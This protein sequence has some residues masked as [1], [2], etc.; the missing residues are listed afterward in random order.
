MSPGRQLRIWLLVFLAF[1][2]FIWL[3]SEMLLPFVAGMAIAYFL[4]P[5]ADRLERLGAPRWMAATIVL[6]SFALVAILAFIL[7]LPLVRSQIVQFAHAVPGWVAWIRE[8]GIPRAVALAE[9]LSPEEV[10]RLKAA[11]SD[12]AGTAVGWVAGMLRGL[13]SGGVAL[14]DVIS[15]LLITPIVAFYLL[16]D[17][18]RLVGAVDGWLPR[19]HVE[20]VREQAREVDD[21]L[22][23][24][25]RGQ[26]TVCLV[27][28]TFYAVALSLAGL[29]FGLVIGMTAGLL[30][31]IPYVGSL[32]GF[33]ASVGIAFF[34]Y[35]ELWRVGLVVGIFIFGQAVEGNFLTPK[36]VG[37]RVG[38]HPVWVMFALLAGGSLYG[39]TGVLLAVPVAAVIGVL[40]RFLLTQYLSSSL[41]TGGTGNGT[42]A[43]PDGTAGAPA[44]LPPAPPAT[45]VRAPVDATPAP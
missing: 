10:E 28:G 32:V 18:D 8:E 38:L 23:G 40:V 45:K 42:S 36:L 37:E 9:R 39:F 33:V 35:D 43:G 21:T 7:V 26:A 27:L 14:F 20:T 31:F 44:E 3:F 29:Q 1:A 15:I 30:S 34:Q 12:Y 41:Y 16:R 4:D 24:F 5:L 11:V 6:L 19:Q 22:A 25:V 2:A 13:L 17:W